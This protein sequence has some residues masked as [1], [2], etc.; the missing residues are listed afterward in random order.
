M[1]LLIKKIMKV[2]PG[3]PVVGLVVSWL[4]WW[5]EDPSNSFSAALCSLPPSAEG[6]FK[7]FWPLGWSMALMLV[8]RWNENW[9]LKDISDDRSCLS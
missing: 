2:T 1:S 5:P 3:A 8:G 9:L 4:A 6:C 7:H